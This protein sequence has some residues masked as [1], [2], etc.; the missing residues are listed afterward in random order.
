MYDEDG[1]GREEK[2]GEGT[3]VGGDPR[4][5]YP[6]LKLYQRYIRRYKNNNI[7]I[8]ILKQQF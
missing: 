5:P 2:E 3:Y 4:R 7:K 8:T 1:E 6:H